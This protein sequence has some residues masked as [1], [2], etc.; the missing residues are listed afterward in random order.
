MFWSL[1][2][3]YGVSCRSCTHLFKDNADRNA[4]ESSPREWYALPLAY[5]LFTQKDWC[6]VVHKK[7]F[8]LKVYLV[9]AEFAKEQRA[10]KCELL[11]FGKGAGGFG[12]AML[13][14]HLKA[15]PA[16]SLYHLISTSVPNGRAV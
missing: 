5:L 7:L 10:C 9:L 1:L 12:N 8:A 6:A 11:G 4:C 14:L 13:T 16:E 15:W 3:V 2:G